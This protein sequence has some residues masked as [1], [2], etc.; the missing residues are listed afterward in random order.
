MASLTWTT[1][2]TTG[3]I[4]QQDQSQ[5]QHYLCRYQFDQ[6]R[7]RVQPPS[8]FAT[9]TVRTKFIDPVY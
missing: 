6:R 2:A 9:E 7:A 4:L 8:F 5:T 3:L 1:P